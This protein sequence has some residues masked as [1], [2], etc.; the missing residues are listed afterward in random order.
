MPLARLALAV[1]AALLFLV[2]GTQL[3]QFDSGVDPAFGLLAYG[4]AFAVLAYGVA[5]LRDDPEKGLKPPAPPRSFYED[6]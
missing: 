1:V 4:A 2:G 3:R 5:G 6:A